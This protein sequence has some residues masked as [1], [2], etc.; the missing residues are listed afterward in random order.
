MNKNTERVRAIFDAFGKGD[1]GFILDQLSDDVRFV[2][3]LDPV[4][5]WAGEFAG[6]S[7]VTRYFQALVGAVEVE[8]HPVTSL[9]TE[10]DMVVAR[11]D[12]R[13]RV[14]ATDTPGASS[15]VY[16]FTLRDGAVQRFDQFND[17]GLA[18]AFR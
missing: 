1:V 15:W 6:K 11:G 5:P 18:T 17:T 10:D 14:R 4:V 16:V 8:D 9:V 3:H 12:V 2:S 13:F 7:D